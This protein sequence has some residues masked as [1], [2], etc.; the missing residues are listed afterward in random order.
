MTFL[1]NVLDIWLPLLIIILG[2]FTA[3]AIID[4]IPETESENPSSSG[5]TDK[6]CLRAVGEENWKEL[7]YLQGDILDE[8]VCREDL[9]AIVNE[10]IVT[11]ANPEKARQALIELGII[12]D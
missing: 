5:F 1:T 7:G 4:S 9:T 3:Y 11:T 6:W 12:E 2:S 10:K 8:L